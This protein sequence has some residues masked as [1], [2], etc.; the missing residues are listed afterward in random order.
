MHVTDCPNRMS[1]GLRGLRACAAAARS[2]RAAA[3]RVRWSVRHAS[4]AVAVRRAR[5]AAAPAV[6]KCVIACASGFVACLRA[7]RVAAAQAPSAR[8]VD[9]VH[10]SDAEERIARVPP[11]VVDAT[12]AACDG[13]APPAAPEVSRAHTLLRAGGGAT[14]HPIEFIQLDKRA[15]AVPATC[16]YCG[17]RF[18][19]KA[20]GHGGEHHEAQHH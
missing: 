15:G 9:S 12:T 1:L 6:R 18:V 16:G 7:R 2:A 3:P 19:M 5:A 8:A 14:G 11:I 17:L 20:H 13:G 4:T 10:R